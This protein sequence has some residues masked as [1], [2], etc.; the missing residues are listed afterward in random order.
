MMP[1]RLEP[2]PPRSRVKHSTT[3]FLASVC[4]SLL[5]CIQMVL[6]QGVVDWSMICE[7]DNPRPYSLVF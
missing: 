4:V 5:V 1:V 7:C 2:V 3:E 6:P